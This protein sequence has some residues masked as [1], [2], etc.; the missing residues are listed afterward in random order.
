MRVGSNQVDAMDA[1]EC[2]PQAQ[3]SSNAVDGSAAANVSTACGRLATDATGIKYKIADDSNNISC[4]YP[5]LS[6]LLKI[7]RNS[8]NFN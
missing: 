5:L 7:G 3:G 1:Q 8:I 6:K 2:A 4:C